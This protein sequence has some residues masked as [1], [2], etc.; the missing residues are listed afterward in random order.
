[1]RLD[2]NFQ[3]DEEESDQEDDF[4]PNQ[5]TVLKDN[6]GKSKYAVRG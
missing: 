3:T 4:T 6:R 5:N 2:D 1:M